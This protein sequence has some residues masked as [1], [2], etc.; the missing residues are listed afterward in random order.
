MVMS[1]QERRTRR[2]TAILLASASLVL[3]AWDIY[4]ANN[5]LH[6]DT[7]SEIV[8]DLSHRFYSL[9]FIVMICMGHFF[10][11]QP[12]EKR[13]PDQERLRV[14]W[15][16]VA[17]LSALVIV[18]DLVNLWVHL[19]SA[20]YANL[21]MAVA[22]FTVGAMYWPQALPEDPSPPAA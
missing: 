14:F 16:R 17:P 10:W 20:P 6:N 1:E 19:P 8:R 13:L 2:V 5:D 4:V 21:A 18:R 15:T 9:P 22:G 11:N 12:R 7:I 3:L